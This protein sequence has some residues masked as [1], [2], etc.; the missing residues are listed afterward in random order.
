LN[1]RRGWNFTG[2]AAHL[3]HLRPRISNHRL[4][5]AYDETPAVQAVIPLTLR[6]SLASLR[7]NVYNEEQKR[8]V[9]FR[10]IER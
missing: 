10:E 2:P 9:G 4:Q 3:H 7:L 1:C 6:T 5:Q 8:M